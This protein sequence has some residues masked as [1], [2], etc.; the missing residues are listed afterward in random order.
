MIENAIAYVRPQQAQANIPVVTHDDLRWADGLAWGTPTRYGNMSA[1]MKQFV[2]TTGGLW[3]KGELEDK[4]TGIFTSTATIHRA[5][6]LSIMGVGVG[7][8]AAANC[9]RQTDRCRNDA[10][11]C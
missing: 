10:R 6:S 4:A 5:R 2:D 3:L 9:C 1:Q 11:R 8:S 7:I